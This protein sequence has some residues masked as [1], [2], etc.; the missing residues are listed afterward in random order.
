MK[1][2]VIIFGT[3]PETIK[4]APLIL[5]LRKFSSEIKTVL[6]ATAQHREMLDQVLN[7]FK[8]KPDFDLNIMTQRQTLT[9]VSRRAL[10]GLEKIFKKEKPEL[11]IVQGDTTTAFVAGLVSFYHKIRVAHIEAGLRTDDK[12][13]PFPEELNRRLLSVV[14]DIH[15]AP[16]DVA[17]GNLLKNG[18]SREQIFIT[19]NT[20]VD[21]LKFIIK[22]GI[23]VKGD[24]FKGI[25][26]RKRK[27]IMVTAHRR[28]S[29]GAP[30]ANICYAL[31][32]IAERNKD[33]QIIYPVH[34][35]PNVRKTVFRILD[36][37]ERIY[38]INPLDYI[39]FVYLMKKSY[40]I[41]TD[42]GGVQEE[43]PTLKK[44]VLVLRKK[45]ER[46]EAIKANTAKLVGTDRARIVSMTKELLHQKEV[47]EKMVSSGNPFGDGKASQRIVRHL[48]HYLHQTKVP[49]KPFSPG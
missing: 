16:T 22:K 9:E 44:P 27:T 12:Y 42:S 37:R 40:L 8:I 5:E 30:L 15:Y 24:E 48:R 49:P 33:V 25:D 10:L 31:A 13:N 45:T 6:V 3:R 11:V 32:D 19:G 43:A 36:G 26:F 41:L 23:L 18:I 21:A 28:E 34:L 46:T 7:I 4:L 17:Y 14:A 29:F 39:P 38:L 47:Y 20:V 1:K 35:N 2:I